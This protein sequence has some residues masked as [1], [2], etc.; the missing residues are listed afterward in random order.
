MRCRQ[1]RS[2]AKYQ[3]GLLGPA[4]ATRLERHLEG[5][6]ACRR[7]L[8]ALANT[9]DLLRPMPLHD[10]PRATWPGV[11]A[12]LRPRRSA[13]RV[14]RWVPALSAVMLLLLVVAVLLPLTGHGPGLTP[15]PDSDGYVQVQLAAAWDNPL[16]DKAALGLAICA[17]DDD[18]GPL[19]VLN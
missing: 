1:S 12:R 9:V 18:D 15:L 11:Q 19:E 3:V 2:L 10:A 4:E 16:A 8:A 5:C 7:E 13:S 17:A 14:R 6:P